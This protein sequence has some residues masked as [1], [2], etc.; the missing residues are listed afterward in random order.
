MQD[1]LVL[2]NQSSDCTALS[3]PQAPALIEAQVIVNQLDNEAQR[4]LE[5]IQ[6]LI[7]PCDRTTYGQK[8]RE[9]AEKLGVSVR[10]IQ[11]LVK[12]W[13]QEGIAGI[14]KDS[15]RD[16]GRHR[17]GDFW[18]NFIIK[19]YKEGNKGSKGMTPKQV[20]VRSLRSGIS[21]LV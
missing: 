5:I 6:S 21:I 1:S 10:S 15:R 8:L 19:T 18:E 16:K 11:R 17:I 13:E 2:N 4:K 7:E 3:S 20:A 12:R 14:V 9:A